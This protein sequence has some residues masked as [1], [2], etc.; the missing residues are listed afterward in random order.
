MSYYN[1]LISKKK[2]NNDET[3]II[4]CVIL[5]CAQLNKENVIC[6][7]IYNICVMTSIVKKTLFLILVLKQQN[8]V[9]I[10]NVNIY[11]ILIFVFAVS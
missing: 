9:N 8:A 2:Q 7:Y 5:Y 1:L 10:S 3:K 6:S 11:L 4:F